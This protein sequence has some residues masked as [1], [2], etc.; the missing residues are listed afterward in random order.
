MSNRD[1]S[2]FEW[3]VYIVLGREPCPSALQLV[4]DLGIN[5]HDIYTSKVF[6]REE[7]LQLFLLD[8]EVKGTRIDITL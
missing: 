4:A 3:S 8:F 7:L 1:A 2:K 6:S 5:R